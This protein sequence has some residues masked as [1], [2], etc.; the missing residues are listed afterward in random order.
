M[1]RLIVANYICN[2]CNEIS[3]VQN[4]IFLAQLLSEENN[5]HIK[6]IDSHPHTR[7]LPDVGPGQFH[8]PRPMNVVEYKYGVV[9][10][11]AQAL[12]KVP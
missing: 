1:Y 7:V 6:E 5:S 10:D 12:V 9:A 8:I 2:K 4:K 11:V 3:E